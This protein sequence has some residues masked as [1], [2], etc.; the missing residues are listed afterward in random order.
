MAGRGDQTLLLESITYLPGR[1]WG[2]GMQPLKELTL[3]Q[4]GELKL[5]QNGTAQLIRKR[6]TSELSSE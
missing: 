2:H 6:K 3:G 1:P 5:I 4:Y